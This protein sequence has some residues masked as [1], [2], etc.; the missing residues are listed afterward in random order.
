[1]A[2]KDIF[3]PWHDHELWLIASQEGLLSVSGG[4]QHYSYV[5]QVD[6]KSCCSVIL[7][8]YKDL[9]INMF[10]MDCFYE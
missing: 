5:A 2:V 8:F 6:L 3:S 4:M 7:L 10:N 9:H 1:M